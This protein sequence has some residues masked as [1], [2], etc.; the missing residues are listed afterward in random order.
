[1]IFRD[2]IPRESIVFIPVSRPGNTPKNTAKKARDH[3]VFQHCCNLFTSLRF[4]RFFMLLRMRFLR[5]TLEEKTTR[6]RGTE[7][8]GF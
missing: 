6:N 3:A 2:F 4:P 7:H 8:R 5:V 1:M